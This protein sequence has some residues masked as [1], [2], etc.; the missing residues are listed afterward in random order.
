[1]PTCHGWTYLNR[2]LPDEAMHRLREWL[3]SFKSQQSSDDA[4]AEHTIE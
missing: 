3:L 4:N 1:M 2:D